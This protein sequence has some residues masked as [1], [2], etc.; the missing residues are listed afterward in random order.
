MD[1]VPSRRKRTR[2]PVKTYNT[3]PSVSTPPHE[4]DGGSKCSL[5]G[6]EDESDTCQGPSYPFDE[7]EVEVYSPF[8]FFCVESTCPLSAPVLNDLLNLHVLQAASSLATFILAAS[9]ACKPSIQQ[10]HSAPASMCKSPSSGD[11]V[12]TSDVLVYKKQRRY[13]IGLGIFHILALSGILLISLI[14]CVS[15][16]G[17]V[18][19]PPLLH[20]VVSVCDYW[21]SQS[22]VLIPVCGCCRREKN[23]ASAQQ[24]RQ[25]KK[26]HLEA[27]EQRC[28]ELE[29][30]RQALQV[31]YVSCFAVCVSTEFCPITLPFLLRQ[32][33][34]QSTESKQHADELLCAR[35]FGFFSRKSW[36]LKTNNPL[37][38]FFRG[39]TKLESLLAENL[40]LRSQLTTNVRKSAS[41]EQV[42]AQQ[43]QQGSETAGSC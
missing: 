5:S 28:G 14:L 37:L 1:F 39:Q 9:A 11:S 29:K 24:S 25:R 4:D 38:L 30:D 34:K 31:Q 42:A 7:D 20:I 40:D 27:L 21:F 6:S 8:S 23:R 3:R 19:F 41:A 18:Q 33:S 13:A 16:R 12:G 17:R 32:T 36:F 26:C 22:Y 35:E 43:T 2:E 15:R 10:P